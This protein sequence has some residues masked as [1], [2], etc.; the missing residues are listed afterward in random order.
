MRGEPLILSP[1]DAIGVL[2]DN[3]GPIDFVQRSIALSD[4]LRD[5]VLSFG[6]RHVRLIEDDPAEEIILAE[7]RRL[8]V[9]IATETHR[10]VYFDG[11]RFAP[12]R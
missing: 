2:W 8:A 11:A 5:A 6:D 12:D 7:G 10:P 9:R 3:R 1:E 4:D